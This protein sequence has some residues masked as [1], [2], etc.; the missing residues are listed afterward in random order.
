MF[1]PVMRLSFY[2]FVGY[3]MLLSCG[4]PVL[5]GRLMDQDCDRLRWDACV[6]EHFGDFSYDFKFS[7][8]WHRPGLYRY[9]WHGFFSPHLP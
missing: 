9:D 2:V 7:F 8:R 1:D 6:R 3:R 5:Q 4:R